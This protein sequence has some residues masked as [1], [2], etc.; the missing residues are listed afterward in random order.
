M[1]IIESIRE[2]CARAWNTTPSVMSTPCRKTNVVDAKHA[3]ALICSRVLGMSS[4]QLHKAIENQR[5]R[6]TIRYRRIAALR[7]M[8]TEP[9]F[10][11]TVEIISK[12]ALRLKQQ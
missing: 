9:M 10:Q 7:K 4:A 3:E 1:N 5:H 12:E 2:M 11:L 8:E 6:S